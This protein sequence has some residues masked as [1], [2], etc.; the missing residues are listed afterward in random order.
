MEILWE[1]EGFQFG[2][3]WQGWAVSKVLWK[4]I[5]IQI[6]ENYETNMP[7]LPCEYWKQQPIYSALNSLASGKAD[8]ELR[9]QINNNK[10]TNKQT[11]KPLFQATKLHLNNS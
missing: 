4:W 7:A 9:K 1:E 11:N 8:H 6:H 10:Q 3:K 5:P 2:F